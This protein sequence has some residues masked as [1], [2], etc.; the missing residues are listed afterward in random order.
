MDLTPKRGLSI[1]GILVRDD[2]ISEFKVDSIRFLGCTLELGINHTI[3]LHQIDYIK[4]RLH[5]R[6][7]EI[8]QG[9][10][11]LPESM[12]GKVVPVTERTTP[13]YLEMKHL[14]QEEV[15][16]LIWIAS[17]T[18]PDIAG[19]VSTAAT[20]TTFNPDEGFKL[21]KGVWMYLAGTV[22]YCLEYGSINVS[23]VTVF[24]D[25]SFAPGG[26]R[27]RSGVVVF[28]KGGLVFL[29][30]EETNPGNPQHPRI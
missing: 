27:S 2:A 19:S 20:L 1:K 30:Y 15:G 16:V 22:D 18:H 6:G 28:W 9:R 13:H 12:E 25:A 24:T 4:E 3:K 8:N 23:R 14:C 21:I 26:D 29:E 5:E 7:R 11:G 17:R 10:V